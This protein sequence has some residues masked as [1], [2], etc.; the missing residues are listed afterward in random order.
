MAEI[1]IQK[2]N[3][4]TIRSTIRK[5]SSEIKNQFKAEII[6][7]FGS[8]ARNEQHRGSDVDVLVRFDS[9]ATLFDLVALSDYLEDILDVPVDVV[10]EKA[11]HPMMRD[12]V[13]N[14]LVV[15]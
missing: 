1:M 3:A 13:M 10:S 9:G 5:F 2:E 4:D 15:V 14:E 12:D 8:Y 6:G 7:I 11:L